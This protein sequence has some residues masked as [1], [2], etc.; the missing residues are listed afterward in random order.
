MWLGHSSYFI[1][2]NGKKILVDPVLSGKAMFLSSYEGSNVYTYDDIPDIDYLII[3]HDHWDHLDYKTVTRIKNRVGKVLTGLGT[4]AHLEYWGYPADKVVEHDWNETTIL[5]QGFSVTA[6]RTRHFSGRFR[7]RNSSLWAAFALF[8]P[9]KKIYI[10]GDSG[11]GDHFKETGD[12]FGPFD[13]AILDSGQYNEQ[14]S[15]SHMFPE[16]T[17]QAAFDLKAKQLFGGHWGKFTLSIHT[18]D[19]PII[20]L[21]AESRKRGM[22]L[23]HPM[24]GERVDLNSPA[25]FSRWWEN[26]DKDQKI[27][28]SQK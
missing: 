24:I 15:R 20:R 26:V 22:P 14:W 4:G 9:T 6:L 8:T 23:L 25:K 3:T 19:D 1:Q 11:Y 5:D 10:G 27:D 2:I 18:W 21:T 13:L 7:T 17:V 12:R 16:Q 28:V